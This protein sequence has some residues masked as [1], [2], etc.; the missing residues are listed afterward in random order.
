MLEDS[1]QKKNV[2]YTCAIRNSD[3][4]VEKMKVAEEYLFELL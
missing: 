4:V 2:F 1:F 3:M